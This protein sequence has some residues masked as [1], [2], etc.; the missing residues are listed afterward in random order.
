VARQDGAVEPLRVG[1]GADLLQVPAAQEEPLDLG[2]APL[3]AQRPG[4]RDAPS[5]KDAAAQLAET[6][7]R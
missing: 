1:R 6:L 7:Q 4:G 3:V 5:A 2:K